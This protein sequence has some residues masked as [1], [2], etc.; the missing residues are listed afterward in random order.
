MANLFIS[1][2]TVNPKAVPDHDNPR[3]KTMLFKHKK[4]PV[5]VNQAQNRD[6]IPA[7]L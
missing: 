7:V 5:S 3:Q 4:L 1:I 6:L 2:V